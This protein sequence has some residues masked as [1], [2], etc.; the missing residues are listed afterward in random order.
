MSEVILLFAV[1]A[2]LYLWE[3]ACWLPPG[4]LACVS[5]LGKKWRIIRPGQFFGNQQGGFVLAPP[6][7]PLGTILI[8]NQPLFALSP[9]GIS[10]VG[11]KS[12]SVFLFAE[13]KTVEAKGHK[14]FINGSPA[15][16]FPTQ[17]FAIFVTRQ[18]L[19]LKNEKPDR[20]AAAIE[21]FFQS[22]FDTKTIEARW[23]DFKPETRTIQLLA[24]GLFLYLFVITP[25][26]IVRFGLAMTWLSLVIGLV[27]FTSS[28][29]MMC[30]R[31]HKH[32][33][34]AADDDR[35]TH[36][37]TVLLAPATAIRARDALS[38]RLLETYHPLAIAGAFCSA[39]NFRAFAEKTLRDLRYSVAPAYSEK[40]RARQEAETFSR[41][42][43]LRV[44]ENFLRRNKTNPDDLCAAPKREETCQ[45][46]CPRCL[47]QFTTIDG[48]CADCGGVPLVTFKEAAGGK[49]AA[50]RSSSRS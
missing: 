14:V 43:L 26:M 42:A 19:D 34:P 44:V 6:L 48:Q 21:K 39:E 47:T 36:T 33:F 10:I 13:I 1:L 9:Q 24:S 16:K 30:Y 38:R 3:C 17:T 32:F 8:G 11:K 22:L 28:L 5:W 27:A 15:L 49:T 29:A 7:P 18:L 25:L 45:S 2:L 4:S 46:F 37:V 12:N 40:E 35:F 50:A 20:R 41:Q 23:N 31:A